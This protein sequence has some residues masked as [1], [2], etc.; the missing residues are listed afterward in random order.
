MYRK[1]LGHR[2]TSSILTLACLCVLAPQGVAGQQEPSSDSLSMVIASLQRQVDTQS[3]RIAQLE[4]EVARLG[5]A[6]YSARLVA[7]GAASSA[8][9][10]TGA[11]SGVAPTGAWMTP[12]SWDRIQAGMSERQVISILGQPTSREVNYIDYVTLYYRGEVA[13]SGFV[14]GNVELNNDDR[15]LFSGINKPIF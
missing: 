7:E 1:R 15:V 6:V 3:E 4:V 5:A 11:A 12:S 10:A 14:S 8:P 13:R 2:A 9:R